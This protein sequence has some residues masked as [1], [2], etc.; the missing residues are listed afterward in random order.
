MKNQENIRMLVFLNVNDENIG[1]VGHRAV[2]DGETKQT[3][4]RIARRINNIRKGK[5]SLW[6]FNPC[7]MS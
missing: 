6:K 3:K 5:V 2:Y 4:Y 1:Y 7:F